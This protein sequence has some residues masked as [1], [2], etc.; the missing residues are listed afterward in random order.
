MF[1]IQH[2]L[3]VMAIS[4]KG[5]VIYP[6]LACVSQVAKIKL[7]DL[8]EAQQQRVARLNRNDLLLYREAVQHLYTYNLDMDR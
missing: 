5:Q 3:L 1:A 8:T 7:E 6:E 4:C 2:T